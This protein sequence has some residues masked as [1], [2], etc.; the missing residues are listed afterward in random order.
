[1]DIDIYRGWIIHE[2]KHHGQTLY[3][4]RQWGVTMNINNLDDLRAM[5]DSKIEDTKTPSWSKK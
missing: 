1:M 2:F 3:Q 5:I 4:A